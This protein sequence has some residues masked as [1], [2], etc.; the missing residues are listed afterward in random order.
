M[1]NKPR[2]IYFNKNAIN[3]QQNPT[4][5]TNIT[6][7]NNLD[8]LK[9]SGLA[10]ENNIGANQLQQQ[11]PI[12]K[13]FLNFN[14]KLNTIVSDENATETQ[15]TASTLANKLIAGG[16][17]QLSQAA[18]SEKINELKENPI[19]AKQ[20]SPKKPLENDDHFALIDF[21]SNEKVTQPARECRESPNEPLPPK[22]RTL[23][24][25]D[26]KLPQ[27]SLTSRI[28]RLSLRLPQAPLLTEPQQKNVPAILQKQPTKRIISGSKKETENII[29]EEDEEEEEEIEDI[30][31]SLSR[32]A[33]YL[34]CDVA[35]DIYEYMYQLEEAQS[36]REDYLK[37][38]K[39]LTPN[40]RQRLINW[41]I[42][43][44]SK[45]NLL[46]ETLYT[47]ISLMD[48][49]FDKVSVKQ[50]SQVQLVAV[51]CTL[52]AS[53]YEEIYP[54]EISQLIEFTQHIYS[55]REIMR[56]EIHILEHLNF[57]LGKP[58]P[59]AFLRRYSKA[60]HSDLKMHSI[61]K[62][63]ME[64]SLNEYQCSHWR[65]SMLA[66]AALFATI[67]LVQPGEISS[68]LLSSGNARKFE[69]KPTQD[70]WTKS[71][72]HYTN[73]TRKELQEPAGVLC[74]ILKKSQKN[75]QLYYCVKKN[76]QS[77]PKWPELK[78]SRVDELIR[79]GD[80]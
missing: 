10:T 4:Q 19:E 79:M 71:L 6:D 52:I 34:V 58:I 9:A 20:P 17:K 21:S 7:A 57:D 61:A 22:L 23:T 75:P 41:C 80:Q 30:D 37:H 65:P 33:I 35:K 5:V 29:I 24:N 60:A 51:G 38:Q 74:K 11:Q 44:H 39:I 18:I 25:L 2:G 53:K 49:F 27:E 55:K 13:L 14:N 42:E 69:Q 63:L 43:I 73:Y 8:N 59:L 47:T 3:I 68:K 12:K 67:H 50:Q 64:L 72:V 32:D 77:I 54:P 48:R 16:L 46:S 31:K 1:N 28:P 62:Y 66:A 45:L 76:L 70:R 15:I 26:F 56:V 40:V 36:V 78:S